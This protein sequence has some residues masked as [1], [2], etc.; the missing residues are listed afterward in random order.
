MRGKLGLSPKLGLGTRDGWLPPRYTGAKFVYDANGSLSGVPGSTYHNGVYYGSVI[1]AG[2]TFT[3][4]AGSKTA[5]QLDGSIVGPFAANTPGETNAGLGVWGARTNKC[6]NTNRNPTVTTGLTLGGD[7]AATLTVVD[8]AAALA[9]AGL[10]GICSNGKVYKLDN[11]AGVALARV[12]IPGVTGNTNPASVSVWWRGSGTGSIGLVSPGGT[13][14]SLPAAYARKVEIL[15]PIDSA[16]TIRVRAQAGAVIYFVLNQL[17][18]GS[19]VSPV[20]PVG[21][22]A[23]TRTADS[24]SIGPT[25]LPP[26]GF[27]LAEWVQPSSANDT[28][29]YALYVSD[30]GNSRLAIRASNGVGD[31][32]IIGVVGDGASVTSLQ[33]SALTEGARVVALLAYDTT[34]AQMAWTVNGSDQ[35]AARQLDPSVIASVTAHLGGNNSGGGKL[36]SNL[37]RIVVAPGFPTLAQRQAL[38]A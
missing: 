25:P 34:S 21:G 29:A 36:N 16:Q 26:V 13:D 37:R 7:A 2:G 18:E 31:R 3:G 19:F 38:T 17:E 9:A 32:S 6:T 28:R 10:T 20:I 5:E 27:I 22:V 35:T 14:V 15:T 33:S 30:T 1:G 4:G 24:L 23:A 8:D 12:D 11:S